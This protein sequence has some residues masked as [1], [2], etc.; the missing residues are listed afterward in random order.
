MWK[1]DEVRLLA[2]QDGTWVKNE[3][4]MEDECGVFVRGLVRAVGGEGDLAFPVW[5]EISG[6]WLAPGRIGK[7]DFL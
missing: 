6:C 7:I 2:A 5:F 1:A 3:R 4:R